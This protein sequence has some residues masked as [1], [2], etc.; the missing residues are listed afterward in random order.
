MHR[1]GG[2][3]LLELLV[4]LALLGLLLLFYIPSAEAQRHRAAVS[5]TQAFLRMART[6]AIRRG[7]LV[8]VVQPTNAANGLLACMDANGNGACDPGESPIRTLSLRGSSL[9]LRPGF[10]PG[11]RFNALGQLNTGARVVV[12]T[13]KHATALCLALTGRIRESPGGR[14]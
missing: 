1:G 3:T 7:S 13:G 5:E 14:C 8:A 9:E 12:R 4:V 6:E 2:V 11:L 10:Q